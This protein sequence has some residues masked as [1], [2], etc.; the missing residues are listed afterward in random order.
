MGKNL[1]KAA[2][3]LLILNGCVKVLGFVREMV[4]ASGF[5]ASSFTDAY[6]AAYTIP[7]FFQTILGYAFVSAVLPMLSQSWRRDGDNT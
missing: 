2:G 6:L 3:W 4:I 1:I 5:G 7:Y